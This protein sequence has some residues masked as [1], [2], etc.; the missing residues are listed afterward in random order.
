MQSHSQPMA[1]VEQGKGLDEDVVVREE[2]ARVAHRVEE[3][4]RLDVTFIQPI[5]QR[6]DCGRIEEDQR[7][8]LAS[9]A[10]AK[11]SS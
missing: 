10:S 11:A 7:R 4:T 3:R 1:A 5:R 8:N 6:D 9:I 2:L